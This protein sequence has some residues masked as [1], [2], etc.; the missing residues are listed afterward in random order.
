[1]RV[2][3]E[4]VIEREVPVKARTEGEP[5]PGY[6]VLDNLIAPE[7]V[8]IT[9]AESEIQK[10]N[11]V[12]TETVSLSGKT[13]PFSMQVAI[14][15]NSGKLALVNEKDRKV[16]VTVVIGEVRKERQFARVPVVITGPAPQGAR[17]FP[18]NVTITLYGPRSL[19]DTL[20]PEE[21]VVSVQYQPGAGATHRY[22]PSVLLPAAYGDSIQV[23]SIEPREVLVK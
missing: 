11:E 3:V 15:L 8:W 7:T 16:M 9:G 17:A 6:T 1:M 10:T 14:D 5:P 2:T 19:M 18:D 12:L 23:I 21:L 22:A 13:E 20:K 4:P